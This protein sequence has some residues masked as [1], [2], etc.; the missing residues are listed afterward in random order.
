MN[1]LLKKLALADSPALELPF[2]AFES[3]LDASELVDAPSLELLPPPPQAES[4]TP[5]AR[6][7]IV[8]MV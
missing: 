3:P 6:A 5:R 4:V 2:D 7:M 1:M 8:A